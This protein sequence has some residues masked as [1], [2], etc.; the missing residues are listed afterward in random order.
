MAIRHWSVATK[1]SHAAGGNGGNGG[2]GKKAT[3]H[4]R[5]GAGRGWIPQ[6]QRQDR[7]SQ[8]QKLKV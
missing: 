1:E 8:W 7:P 6:E 5:D 2:N 4:E 3:R